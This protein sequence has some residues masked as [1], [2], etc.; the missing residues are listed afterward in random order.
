MSEKAFSESAEPVEEGNAKT[1]N[2]VFEL[3]GRKFTAKPFV[4]GFA[5]MDFLEASDGK[6]VTSIVAFRTFLKEATTEKEWAEIDAYCRTSEK[7]IDIVEITKAVAQLVEAYTS[8][9]TEAS[10]Q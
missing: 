1:K 10:D 5:L 7:E 8:R 4:Q 6:D 3:A 9:P 2:K